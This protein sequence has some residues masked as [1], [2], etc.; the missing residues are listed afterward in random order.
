MLNKKL[1]DS[2]FKIMKYIWN[3]GYKTVIS[4]DVADEM[5]KIYKW[6]QTTTL[7]LLLRL[8]KRGFLASQKIGKHTHYTI[9]IKEKEYLKSETKK[10]FGGLHN[11]PLSQLISKLHDK[12]EVSIDKIDALEKWLRSLQEDEE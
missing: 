11:N 7:T 9:L 2:E 10:L 12:E 1:P 5:E 4:K 8:T 6:K 3:T